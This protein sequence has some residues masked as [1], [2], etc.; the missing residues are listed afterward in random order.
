MVKTSAALQQNIETLYK[1]QIISLSHFKA[2]K[3]LRYLHNLFLQGIG[4]PRPL[5]SHFRKIWTGRVEPIYETPDF[6]KQIVLWKNINLHLENCFQRPLLKKV[7]CFILDG[8]TFQPYHNQNMVDYIKK[9][10]EET[11]KSMKR[12]RK[13][14]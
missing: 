6:S 13:V 9:V 1:E 10:L 5:S 12:H 8:D 14:A 11:R 3:K 7:M 4:A 2:A